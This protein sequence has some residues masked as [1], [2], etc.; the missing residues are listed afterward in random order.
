MGPRMRMS[1]PRRTCSLQSLLAPRAEGCVGHLPRG[2]V[3]GPE[4]DH[5]LNTQMGAFIDPCMVPKGPG[6][7][8]MA[9]KTQVSPV[10]PLRTPTVIQKLWVLPT[11]I[12][13]VLS[14]INL[15]PS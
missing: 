3:L 13:K 11:F 1:P 14:N 12:W 9:L 4:Q 2:A 5:W 7:G 10:P 6:P 8:T 15:D